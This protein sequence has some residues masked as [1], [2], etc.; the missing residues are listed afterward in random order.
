MKECSRFKNSQVFHGRVEL[1]QV[2]QSRGMVECSGVEKNQV[3]P[4]RAMIGVLISS[5]AM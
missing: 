5:G 1:N 3:E 4:S 2:E